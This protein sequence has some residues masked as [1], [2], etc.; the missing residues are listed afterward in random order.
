MEDLTPDIAYVY[1]LVW[2]GT[3]EIYIG[4]TS[5][6]LEQRFKDH[7]RCPHKCYEHLGIENAKLGF[8]FDYVPKHNLDRSA[9]ER[10]KRLS[11]AFGYKV[12]DD[13]DQHC[14]PLRM[15][16]EAKC[17]MSEAQKIAMSRPEA[18]RK[19][20]EAQKIAQNRPDI[21]HKKRL[22]QG[23]H[24]TVTWPDGHVKRYLSTPE[25]ASDLGVGKTTIHKYLKGERTPGTGQRWKQTAHLKG[26][27]FA[28]L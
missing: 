13:G 20:S 7:K 24:F 19:N 23:H 28:Y 27:I 10:W 2:P 17:N 11:V 14:T 8:C 4:S 1:E 21:K 5:R 9:E 15:S 12:L 26:C 25:A 18:R 16:E 22:A 3:D 6:T